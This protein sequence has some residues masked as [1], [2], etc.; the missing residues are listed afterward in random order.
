MALLLETMTTLCDLGPAAGHQADVCPNSAITLLF[1]EESVSALNG[2][3]VIG[4]LSCHQV[5]L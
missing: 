5:A 1:F 4:Y 2:N 3:D